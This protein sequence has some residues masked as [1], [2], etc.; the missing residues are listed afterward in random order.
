MR[1][2]ARPAQGFG[3]IPII[4]FVIGIVAGKRYH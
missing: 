4:T 2:G 3:L 1:I